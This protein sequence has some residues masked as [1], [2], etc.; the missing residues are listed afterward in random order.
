MDQ[1]GP[2]AAARLVFMI[3]HFCVCF[4][5]CVICVH[6]WVFMCEFMCARKLSCML[7]HVCEREGEERGREIER[8][9]EREEREREERERGVCVCLSS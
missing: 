3:M 7:I 6:I 1:E 8:E 2:H 4:S 9:R 5:W